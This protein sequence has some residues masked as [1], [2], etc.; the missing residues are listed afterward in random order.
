MARIEAEVLGR[1][2]L[3]VDGVTAPLGGRQLA[4][5]LRLAMARHTP[6]P[7]RRLLEVWPDDTGTDGALRVALTRIRHVLGPN[8]V[9]RVD[10]GYALS[11]VAHVDADRF[12]HLLRRA[13]DDS[14]ELSERIAGI[15]E[16]VGLWR[17][18]AFDGLERLPWVDYEAVR[19]DELYEQAIDLRFEL[20]TRSHH[21]TG[22]IPELT[23]EHGRSPDRER[24]AA[25]LAVALYQA[26]RQTD[27]LAT[28]TRTRAR[29]RDEFGL[30]PGEEL[31]DLESRILRHDPSLRGGSVTLTPTLTSDFDRQIR[32]ALSFVTAGVPEQGLEIADGVVA[33]ARDAGD[34]ASTAR[35]LLVKAQAVAQL[36]SDDP[37]AAIDEAQS[38][39]RS[40]GLGRVLA[41]A[42]L[43]RFGQG[44][45]RDRIAALVELGEPLDMLP[46]S[47]PERIELLCAAAAIVSF[48]DGGPVAQRILRA[49]EQAHVEQRTA[50]SE[51]V[52]WSTRAIIGAVDGV[53]IELL[54]QWAD[55]AVRVAATTNDPAIATVAIQ[56]VLRVSYMLG[57][58][59]A[60]DA[61]LE[62]LQAT[63]SRALLPF[64]TVRVALCAVTNALARAELDR[65]PALIEDARAVGE[66]LRTH[67]AVPAVRTQML[68]LAL[69]SDTLGQHLSMVRDLA[70]AS[71]GGPWLVVAALAGDDSDHARLIG[72][73]DTIARNDSFPAV[74]AL[75]ALVAGCRRDDDLGRWC[76]PPLDALGDLTV[77]V[78]F[79]TGVF[80]FAPFFAGVARLACGDVDG[81]RSR[82]ERAVALSHANGARLWWTHAQLWLADVLVESG[83]RS[84]RR[85]ADGILAEVAAS[86]VPDVSIRAS[87]HFDALSQRTVAG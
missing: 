11:P 49:A 68:M 66:R 75:G 62:R 48:T 50:R 23:A 85:R 28:I 44:V 9:V 57:D 22:L 51:A 76:L 72:A 7:Q 32:A 81:A 2:H 20:L 56:A 39:A 77:T 21:A 13:H 86:R 58:L 67:A 55:R 42:A 40:L 84:A 37:D 87:R 30:Q 19:L 83:G 33:C 18:P 69:E 38:I 54:R 45:P 60:V 53:E 59:D 3:V 17:G 80:G 27:A 46:T 78:G 73:L 26:G 5:A 65:V 35:A 34:G 79:G 16:A 15:G 31:N 10:G 4:L 36:G 63:S 52:W 12:E 61:A 1:P 47:A 74:V 14:I 71:D 25:M 70:V 64:G 6:V 24:R 8:T 41:H 29:L 43:V 82:L